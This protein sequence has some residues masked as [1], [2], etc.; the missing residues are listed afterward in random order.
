MLESRFRVDS[1]ESAERSAGRARMRLLA[2][3]SDRSEPHTHAAR[4]RGKDSVRCCSKTHLA[5]ADAT[6]DDGVAANSQEQNRQA[7]R[8]GHS[9]TRVDVREHVRA[10]REQSEGRQ[11]GELRRESTELV[12]GEH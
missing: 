10:S 2:A 11:G 4:T 9:I 5:S 1:A 12:V 3:W 8:A 6:A 7:P